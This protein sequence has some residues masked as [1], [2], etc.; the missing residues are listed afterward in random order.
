MRSL[1]EE[2]DKYRYKRSKAERFNTKKTSNNNK[3]NYYYKSNF[4][5]SPKNQK[6]YVNY[7][8]YPNPG[9][10]IISTL[11]NYFSKEG[12]AVDGSEPELFNANGNV[13]KED[14]GV[15]KNEPHV[16]HVI[17]SPGNGKNLNL[18]EFAKNAM[19]NIEK[20]VS[21]KLDWSAAVH[22]DT[23]KPHIHIMIRGKDKNGKNLR[24]NPEFIKKEARRY[25]EEL[26]TKELGPR[27]L[28]EINEEKANEISAKRVTSID[29]KILEN[30]E[31]VGDRLFV[32]P[33]NTKELYRLE[34]LV[35]INM[36]KK[37]HQ[38]KKI[39]TI[40]LEDNYFEILPDIKNRLNELAKYLDKMKKMNKVI[41]DNVHKFIYEKSQNIQGNIVY[42]DLENELYLTPYAII[43][44]DDNKYYY[45]SGKV[46]ELFSEGDRIRIVKG[47]V[48]KLITEKQKEELKNQNNKYNKRPN[49]S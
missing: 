19:E 6:V 10:K 38:C 1:I 16:F 5:D 48:F 2:L 12:K 25:C 42:K 37:T 35:G 23:E 46:Y 26:A 14:I 9:A 7:H 39:I 20:A 40:K 44:T 31:N 3:D 21:R 28:R 30:S 11:K 13:C 36:A 41:K 15:I 45:V 18:E 29:Y 49:S 22:Y 27:K 17:I 34:Y 24:F 8:Y 32:R 33:K 43:K 4:I 47:K